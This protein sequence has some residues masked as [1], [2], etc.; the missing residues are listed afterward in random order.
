M[1]ETSAD[2]SDDP[3]LVDDGVDPWPDEL[4]LVCPSL[5]GFPLRFPTL[6]S[7]DRL[8]FPSAQYFCGGWS[9]AGCYGAC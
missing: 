6:V 8:Q 1:E 5:S 7:G 3:L 4:A 2:G 9:P